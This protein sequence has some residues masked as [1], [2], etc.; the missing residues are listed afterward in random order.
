MPLFSA[1]PA[2]LAR[3]FAFKEACLATISAAYV[4]SPVPMDGTW[5]KVRDGSSRHAMVILAD[6]A[7]AGMSWSVNG[8]PAT[9]E[10]VPFSL[11]GG[12]GQYEFTA[13]CLTNDLYVK[14]PSGSVLTL[15]TVP[16]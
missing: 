11:S 8:A 4:Q 12:P 1:I 5:K 9:D 3:A 15:V 14:G 10:G 7:G 2:R 13:P 6:N 16:V